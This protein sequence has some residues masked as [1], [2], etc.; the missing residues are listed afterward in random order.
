[1]GNCMDPSEGYSDELP[2][3]TVYVSAFYMDKYLVT[4][5][6]VGHGVSVGHCS[7]LH[8]RLC[9]FGQGEHAS[10]ADDRLV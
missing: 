8:V 9:G 5:S 7:R 3:H 6:A 4:K 2:L 1:M 10:G